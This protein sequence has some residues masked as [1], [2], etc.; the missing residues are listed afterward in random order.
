MWHDVGFENDFSHRGRQPRTNGHDA[1]ALDWSGARPASFSAGDGT[2]NSR[3][4]SREL[5]HGRRI[6]L[7]SIYPLNSGRAVGWLAFLRARL[8]FYRYTP[9][10]YVHAHCHRRG[11]G[12]PV[13]RSGD[14]CAGR[15]SH[16]TRTGRQGR[17]LFRGGGGD[18][19]A[20]AA[21]P[22]A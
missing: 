19:A 7:D 13:Q 1:P 3:A 21:R 15:V 20:G 12:L 16:F 9:F 6:T 4:G 18:C 14:D 17:N 8:E 10:E 5:D 2:L 11:H 22:G